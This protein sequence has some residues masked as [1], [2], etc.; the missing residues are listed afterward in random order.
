MK[1]R[2]LKECLM[3]VLWPAFLLASVLEMLVFAMVDPQDLHWLGQ[4]LE[5]SNQ[6]VYSVSFFVFWLITT[7]SSA[8]TALLVL[9]ADEVNA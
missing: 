3:A 2:R 1:I 8:L 5:W 7:A 6:G 9:P 4:P